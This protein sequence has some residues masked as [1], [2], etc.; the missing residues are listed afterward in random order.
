MSVYELEE[1]LRELGRPELGRLLDTWGGIDG[2]PVTAEGPERDPAVR[3][4]LARM[5]DPELLVERWLECGPN[6]RAVLERFLDRAD[7]VFPYRRLVDEAPNGLTEAEVE[8]ELRVL[9][10]DGLLFRVEDRYWERFEEPALAMPLELAGLIR[11]QKGD[12]EAGSREAPVFTLKDFLERRKRKRSRDRD[13]GGVTVERAAQH[14]RQAYKLF[15]MPN[16]VLARIRRLPADVKELV[17]LAITNFG[18]LLPRSLFVRTCGDEGAFDRENLGRCLEEALVGTVGYMDLG[19]Y[20]I[21]VAEET[22][23]VFQEVTLIFLRSKAQAER[24]AP[25]ED[26]VAGVDLATNVMRFLRYIDDSGVRYTVRGEIFKATRR[27]ILSQLVVGRGEEMESSFQFLY[28]FCLSR[29]L[30]ERTGERTFRLSE[31]GRAFEDRALTEKLKDLLGFAVQD[32][33]CGGDPFHQVKQR[34]ILLRLLRRLEPEV[35]YDAM[36]VPF[37]ARNSYLAQMESQGVAEFYKSCREQGRYNLIETLERLS[38]HL[39]H[40]V[41]RR[42]HLLGIV[43][44]GMRAGRP[45]ALRLSRLGASLLAGVPAQ[46]VEG[47]RSTLVVNPDFEVLLFPESDAYQLVHTLDR[48]A[49]R[50]DSE[51]LFRF[52]LSE[53][54]VRAALADGMAI[55]EILEVLTDRCRT[56]MPQNVLFSLRDWADRAGVLVLDRRRRLVARRPET[57]DRMLAHARVRELTGQRLA[58]TELELDSSVAAEDFRALLRDLGFHLDLSRVLPDPPEDR[59]IGETA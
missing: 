59:T 32:P 23:V 4:L 15:L 9:E 43:D 22:L 42:L 37:L 12:R 5:R 52:S 34:R 38:W 39:F 55:A 47:G 27:R 48:F 56:P 46:A 11:R 35:W 54:S 29:R 26:R 8:A 10:H 16:A 28:Q 36:Y 57:I 18:G 50:I 7:H 33:C 19:D 49:R 45:V 1:L 51:R 20:G 17:E 13:P 40:W 24:P 14:A 31:L 6:R 2:V 3:A 25:P 30:I 21:Q 41:R 44:L 53:E 58:P